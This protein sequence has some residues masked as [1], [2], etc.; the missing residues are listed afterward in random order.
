MT[1][2]QLL[3]IIGGAAI[4]AAILTLIRRRVR[5][6]L[7]T[8]GVSP[9]P[10]DEGWWQTAVSIWLN[11]VRGKES[12]MMQVSFGLA[13]MAVSL[14]LGYA[15]VDVL[16]LAG[17]Q[18][19]TWLICV[20]ILVA[21]LLPLQHLPRLQRPD[22][23][24]MGLSLGGLILIILLRIL[25]LEIIPGGLH[26]DEM[27]VADFAVRHVYP[28]N[29]QTLNPFVTGVSS[30]P[31]LY[32]YLVR[33]SFS[34]FGYSITG[35]RLL[36]ALGG[37]LGVLATFWLIQQMAGERTAFIGAAIMTTYHYHIHWS[38]LGLNNVW[39]TLWVPL[40]LAAFA[41][42]WRRDWSGGAVLA[43]LAIGLS[44]YF[45]AGNKIGIFLLVYLAYSL[46]RQQ[47]DR[48]KLL[49]YGGKLLV[50]AVT[51]AAPITLFALL[52]P[53]I[54]LLRTRMVWGWSEGYIVDAIG[55]YNL[56]E[57]LWFQLWRNFG[58]FTAVP[59][60][61]GFYGPG[62]PFLLGLAAPLFVMGFFWALWRRQFLPVLW[63]LLTVIFGGILLGGAPSSSHYVVV[64]PAICWLTAEPLN[65]LWK[66]G[67]WQLSLFLLLAIMATDLFF[68]FG[69]YVPGEPR[70]LFNA[71]PEWPL[72]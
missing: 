2:S 11:D 45:Y 65:Y 23:R 37:I 38:R 48:T 69:I 36:T 29:G 58:A 7:A 72:K 50:T 40:T 35:L 57:Y 27:G 30:Q 33:L 24:I 49:I 54:Y 41:W 47:P 25:F 9:S 61:T 28:G 56:G 10:S 55:Q 42:G 6:R 46:Y 20:A 67:R 66:N 16:W 32:H 53:D 68:Y 12:H 63:V 19:W 44:Q 34:I 62:V 18:L 1:Q 39:D 13:C 8:V 71:M 4:L 64:I 59:D 5:R 14:S 31:A 43:G 21:A 3:T 22:R 26:V 15:Y 52:N 70:D 60:V 17:W 51:V